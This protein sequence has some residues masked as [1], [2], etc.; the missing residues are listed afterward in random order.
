MDVIGGLFSGRVV[1]D[2]VGPA[3]H[4]AV[5]S[6]VNI[7]GENISSASFSLINGARLVRSNP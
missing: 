3:V 7:S 6:Q 5:Q 2:E 1:R 4:S